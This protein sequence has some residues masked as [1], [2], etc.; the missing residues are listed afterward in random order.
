MDLYI[1]IGLN[2]LSSISILFLLAIGLFIIFGLMGIVNLAHGEFVMLGAFTAVVA[3]KAGLNPWLSLILAPIVLGI[4]SMIVEKFLI[5]HLYGK[6]MESI[7]AT[8]GFSII[9]IKVTE[10]LFGKGYQPINAPVN[11]TISL[12]GA[13][14]PLYRILIILISILIGVLILIIERKTNIG[15][16]IRAVIENPS[17]ASTLGVNVNKV[18]QL[19]FIFGGAMAGFAGALIAPLVSVY[20]AMGFNYVIDG[21]LAVLL[22]GAGIVG[23]VG[24]TALLGGS[25]SF[26]SYLLDP[27][28]GSIA[29][30]V[31]TIITMRLRHANE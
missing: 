30:V 21:F 19:T 16:T 3:G 17:L 18:Y 14:Y 22:G 31:I 11:S 1:T 25:N 23:L 27:I 4:F 8:V 2:M 13:D 5:R 15:F 29:V 9:L 20:P 6:I 28:W 7:L 26:I 10:W 12:M 24:S